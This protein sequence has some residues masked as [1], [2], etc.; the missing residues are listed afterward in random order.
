LS[1][2][3]SFYFQEFEKTDKF[4]FNLAFLTSQENF[5][6]DEKITIIIGENGC[7][8]STLLESL[9][10][11]IGL[12]TIAKNDIRADETLSGGQLLNKYLRIR[13]SKATQYGLFFRA[14]DVQR[15]ITRLDT[16]KKELDQSIAELE[17]ELS[18]TAMIAPKQ[19]LLEEKEA[20]EEKYGTDLNA[21][22]HG[23]AFLKVFEAR[24][25]RPGVYILDEPEASLSPSRQIELIK[26]IRDRVKN[27][28]FQFILAT[29]S[30]I[31]MGIPASQILQIVD[32]KIL[33]IALENTEHFKITKAFLTNRAAFFEELAEIKPA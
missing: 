26:I 33:P 5:I 30:P 15:L 22:S 27:R 12:P 14:E 8:K 25:N 13:W 20:I 9:A 17:S 7:G 2:I 23:E 16:L 18:E 32:D 19:M 3:K 21:F 31:L 1:F 28:G 29:H 10:Y 6:L 4:P 11:S 24:L